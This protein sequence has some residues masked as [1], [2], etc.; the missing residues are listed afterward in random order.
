M[1][2]SRVRCVADVLVKFLKAGFGGVGA[3]A[4]NLLALPVIS[5]LYGPEEYAVW[6]LVLAAAGIFG[7]IACFRYE[8]A[9]V[10]PPEDEEASAL[11][12]WCVVSSFC[13]GLFVALGA[14]VLFSPGISLLVDAK[15]SIFYT[16]YAPLLIIAMGV[17][18]SLQYWTIRQQ[19]FAI[20]S[21]SQLGM[22][23]VTLA[24]Q[25]GYAV[26]YDGQ[27]GGLLAGSLVG[28]LVAVLVL[29]LG[30]VYTETL[31]GISRHIFAKIPQVLKQHA[32][33]LKYSTPY[34]LFGTLR[35]RASIY[36]LA[37]FL[38]PR[39]VGLYA[40]AYR[41]LNFPVSLISSAL[42]PVIFQ[43]AAAKGSAA[44]EHKINHI[45]RWLA[46]LVTPFVVIYFFY[47]EEL[48]SLFFGEKWVDAEYYG[49][50]FILPVFTLL[51]CNW[52]DRIMDVIGQQRLTMIMEI[53][54]SVLS[55]VGLWS[56]FFFGLGLFGALM[57]QSIVLIVYNLTYLV[58]A[59]D[60]AG[61]K[62]VELA[63]LAGMVVGIASIFVVGVYLIR[64]NIEL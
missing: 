5:R 44:L 37:L 19:S 50:F 3:Q 28:Q 22:A 14:F 40:F 17:T 34:S 15:N 1:D 20:N 18:L 38:S 60:R 54:F 10:I 64:P 9:I 49:K 30:N 24:V 62:K 31:P 25:V 55:I 58:V 27:A 45:L 43:E 13:M 12:W 53:A 8:L 16:L 39:D 41:I 11:F 46:V 56:G 33:F 7:G 57:I 36:V 59:Y 6:A 23:G 63:R 32:K 26:L 42:R 4:V 35:A 2:W 47:A 48:F 29:C 21:I 61:Y 51:F 52:M